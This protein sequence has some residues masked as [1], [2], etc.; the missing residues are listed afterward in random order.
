MRIIELNDGTIPKPTD[1]SCNIPAK[2]HSVEM[3]YLLLDE[4]RWCVLSE[5]ERAQFY[6]YQH[7]ENSY[8]IFQAKTLSIDHS[9]CCTKAYTFEML[10]TPN[11]LL[12]NHIIKY[13]RLH[14]ALG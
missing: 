3:V 2:I 5:R 9:Q 4:W 12:F 11:T 13:C 8:T 10:Q 7:I 6:M 1:F 14:C